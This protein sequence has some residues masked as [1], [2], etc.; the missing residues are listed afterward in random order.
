M[1]FRAKGFGALQFQGFSRFSALRFRALGFRGLLLSF[2]LLLSLRLLPIITRVTLMIAI[3]VLSCSCH[4]I[5]SIAAATTVE[6][7][8]PLLSLY[9]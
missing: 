2:F 1:R 9:S 6:V 8:L 4:H 5:V 7:T 3:M